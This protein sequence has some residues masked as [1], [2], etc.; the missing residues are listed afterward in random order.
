MTA[1]EPFVEPQ[2]IEVEFIKRGGDDHGIKKITVTP[3]Y[4]DGGLSVVHK[5]DFLPGEQGWSVTH[6][7][8]GKKVFDCDFCSDAIQAV[9]D[10]NMLEIDWKRPV[11][12]SHKNIAGIKTIKEKL[13]VLS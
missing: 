10:L 3:V 4:S 7:L 12:P 2:T 5:C 9:K 11:Y 8:T 13:G 1:A 6:D